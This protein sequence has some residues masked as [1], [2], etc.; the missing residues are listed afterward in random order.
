MPLHTHVFSFTH[1]AVVLSNFR[2]VHPENQTKIF[3]FYI[4]ESKQM[5]LRP[6]QDLRCSLEQSIALQLQ[7][8]IDLLLCT[9]DCFPQ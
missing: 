9:I 4:Y 7:R 3:E 8:Q 2:C 6:T 1:N 5:S